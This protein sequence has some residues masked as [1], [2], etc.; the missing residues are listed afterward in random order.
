M[1]RKLQQDQ[2]A[3]Q[4]KVHD[5]FKEA[6]NFN[7]VI[8]ETNKFGMWIPQGA[9]QYAAG[10]HAHE[11]THQ[12]RSGE[13]DPAGTY[14]HTIRQR[15]PEVTHR[16]KH[17]PEEKEFFILG[18]GNPE[19]THNNTIGK[20]EP[21]YYIS[22]QG[23]LEI[24]HVELTKQCYKEF[25]LGPNSKRIGETASMYMLDG[26]LHVVTSQSSF[27]EAN[28]A[29]ACKRAGLTVLVQQPSTGADKIILDNFFDHLFEHVDTNNKIFRELGTP[30]R[31]TPAWPRG[32]LHCSLSG[33]SSV[34][35]TAINQKFQT[36][37]DKLY[38]GLPHDT[39]TAR[40]RK[41]YKYWRGS[42]EMSQETRTVEQKLMQAIQLTKTKGSQLQVRKKIREAMQLTKTASPGNDIFDVD[43]LPL[44]TAEEDVDAISHA[45]FGETDAGYVIFRKEDPNIPYSRQ[46]AIQHPDDAPFRKLSE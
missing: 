13:P 6:L 29:T 22:G 41:L 3:E 20:R 14:K 39:L 26:K 7:P 28:V 46:N 10:Q 5:M 44:S 2:N 36:E 27:R 37:F 15:E 4:Q 1:E 18:Q 25:F 8:K 17:D 40:W 23:R 34:G 33:G 24:P 9:K 31:A 21:E 43:A 19:I 32:S 42:F 12:Y 30:V 35:V 38:N 16:G 45:L 11:S